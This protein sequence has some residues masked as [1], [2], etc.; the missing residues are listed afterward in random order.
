M[1]PE[2]LSFFH[3]SSPLAR[4]H[5]KA[6]IEVNLSIVVLEDFNVDLSKPQICREQKDVCIPSTVIGY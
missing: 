2:S 5:L 1:Y 6:F 3:L 4:R